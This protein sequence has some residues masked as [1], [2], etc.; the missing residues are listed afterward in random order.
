MF[1]KN[2]E[3]T[4]FDPYRNKTGSSV[5]G[6]SVN[7]VN[8]YCYE[9]GSNNRYHIVANGGQF[10]KNTTTKSGIKFYWSSGSFIASGTIQIYGM[11]A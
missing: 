2:Y 11:K 6:G 8:Q 10:Q 4:L 9:G 3:L 5:W 7:Y 1:V